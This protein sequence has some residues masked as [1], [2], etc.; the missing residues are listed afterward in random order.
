MTVKQI[1][2]ALGRIDS[3]LTN[4]QGAEQTIKQLATDI[5]QSSPHAAAMTDL[6]EHANKLLERALALNA[7]ASEINFAL[8]ILKTRGT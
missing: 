3:Q 7:L 2:Q 8:D 5:C 1:A 4:I 6:A